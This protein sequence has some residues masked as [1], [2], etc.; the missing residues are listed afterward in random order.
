MARG[1]EQVE[2]RGASASADSVAV[3]FQDIPCLGQDKG[4]VAYQM[5]PKAKISMQVKKKSGLGWMRKN[6]VH[7]LHTNFHL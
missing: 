5:K 3:C 1:S 7:E 2:G 6:E 4:D